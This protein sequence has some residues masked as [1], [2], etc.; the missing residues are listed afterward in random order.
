VRSSKARRDFI[1]TNADAH[2]RLGLCD[3]VEARRR[4]ELAWQARHA[5]VTAQRLNADG[6]L[7]LNTLE[8][9]V[10]AGAAS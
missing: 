2:V 4:A 10:V 6:R 5:A 1:G 3:A 8:R 7:V 9:F